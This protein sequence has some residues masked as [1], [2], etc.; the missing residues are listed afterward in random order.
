MTDTS[1]TTIYELADQFIALAN[2]LSQ[3]EADVGKVGTALRFAAARFNAFEAA[4]KSADLGAEKES[5]LEWF[6][7]E[8]KEM[9]SDNLDDHIANPPITQETSAEESDNSVQMF[10]G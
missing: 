8:F 1:N 2:Q 10:K 3:Q 9:L 5:A 4:I 7:S 6:S